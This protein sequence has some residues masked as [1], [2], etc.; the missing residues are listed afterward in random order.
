MYN[1]IGEKVIV[2]IVFLFFKFLSYDNI[3]VRCWFYSVII[4]CVMVIFIYVILNDVL[5]SFLYNKGFII[6]FNFVLSVG[7]IGLYDIY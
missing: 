4:D 7:F 5:I 2:V 6:V 3:D 1:L